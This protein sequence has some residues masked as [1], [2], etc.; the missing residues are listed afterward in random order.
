MACHRRSTEAGRGSVVQPGT[1]PLI[2]KI[3]A[4]NKKVM[5]KPL[6]KHLQ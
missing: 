3:S 5:Q 6:T 4:K 2:P 1:A